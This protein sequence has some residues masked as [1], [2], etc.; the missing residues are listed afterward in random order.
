MRR[1]AAAVVALCAVVCVDG[2]SLLR[3]PAASRD[4]VRQ[5]CPR[6][7]AQAERDQL[8]G[9]QEGPE[10]NTVVPDAQP[11]KPAASTTS[12]KQQLLRQCAVCDRGYGASTSERDQIEELVRRLASACPTPTPA[13]GLEGSGDMAL[14]GAWRLI[15]TSAIDV[16]SL[17]ANPVSSVGGVYQNVREDGVIDNLIDILNP[18]ALSILPPSLGIDSTLRL[19]VRTR[20]RERGPA[21]VGLIFEKVSVLPMRFLGMDTSVC[22]PACSVIA[23][24]HVVREARKDAHARPQAMM[25]L[26]CP[27]Q[28]STCRPSQPT[29]AT[30]PTAQRTLT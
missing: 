10:Q 7:L 13:A 1:Q 27:L 19:K 25:S 20:A 8:Q 28:R 16:L 23:C 17:A 14:R 2:F 18:R 11:P 9:A 30:A 4:R 22:M 21:R 12:L 29:A 15:Y 24:V 26:F 3:V 6:W 5:V